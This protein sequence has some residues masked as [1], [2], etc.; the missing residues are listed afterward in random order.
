MKSM[1]VCVCV[2]LCKTVNS[3]LPP[4]FG[5]LTTSLEANTWVG[6]SQ[7]LFSG[8]KWPQKNLVE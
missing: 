7:L 3:C 6:V 4:A 1:C 5:W 2:R 8:Y